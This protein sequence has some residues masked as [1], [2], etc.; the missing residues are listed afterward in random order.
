MSLDFHARESVQGISKLMKCSVTK[1]GRN[2]TSSFAKL[3]TDA[4]NTF[5]TKY[6]NV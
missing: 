3:F 1:N 4:V 5:K 2:N 6:A